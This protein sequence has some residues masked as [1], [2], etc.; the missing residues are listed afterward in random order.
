MQINTLEQLQ[1][2]IDKC[3]QSCMWALM[4]GDVEKVTVFTSQIKWLQEIE[5]EIQ[6]GNDEYLAGLADIL[7][8][9]M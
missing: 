5:S 7:K 2:M 9:I 6:Q 3:K 1:A 4:N 8:D